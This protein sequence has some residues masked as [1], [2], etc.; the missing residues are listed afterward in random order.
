MPILYRSLTIDRFWTLL[1]GH[2]PFT[3]LIPAARRVKDTQDG[4]LRRLM[5][6]AVGD[7]PFVQIEMG[8][9]FG[10]G[11]IPTTTFDSEPGA[12]GTNG[13]DYWLEGRTSDFKI[14]VIYETANFDD[15]DAL[16]MTLIEA[17]EAGGRN[18]G[19]SPI[20]KWGPWRAKRGGV[21]NIANVDRPTTQIIMPVSYEFTGAEL[22]P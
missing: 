8:D 13:A 20:T 19:Y 22:K 7:F 2:A 6:R 18:L 14:S 1:E 12:F 15:Q 17:L 5:L 21:A 9:N 11:A 10:G 16:E 3:A 4:W